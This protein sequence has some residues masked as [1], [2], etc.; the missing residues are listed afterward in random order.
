MIYL[1]VEGV[2]FVKK[3]N[4]LHL[5][6]AVKWDARNRGGP[7]ACPV[8]PRC[9]HPPEPQHSAHPAQPRPGQRQTLP[10]AGPLGGGLAWAWAG[11]RGTGSN[12]GVRPRQM[13]D[14]FQ[15]NIC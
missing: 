7:R 15:D 1:L 13:K 6:R 2:Q 14:V 11:P 12:L 10:G 5:W 3:K 9:W 4:P 8:L